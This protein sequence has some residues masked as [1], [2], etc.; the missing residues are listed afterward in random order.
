MIHSYVE[1]MTSWHEPH[2][3]L[4]LWKRLQ[5]AHV[6]RSIVFTFPSVVL[7]SK[8]VSVRG[9]DDIALACSWSLAILLN[10]FGMARLLHAV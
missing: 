2:Y 3:A 4:N 10:G 1:L 5:R 9:E 7:C 6:Q 8:H